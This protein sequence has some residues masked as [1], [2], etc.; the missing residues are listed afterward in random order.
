M[1]M[2]TPPFTAQL[3]ADGYGNLITISGE[4]VCGISEFLTTWGLVVGLTPHGYKRRYCFECRLDAT[5]ALESWR[6]LCGEH[7]P[8]PWIK[9]KGVGIDLLNPEL[10]S[11]Q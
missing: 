11:C 10:T 3:E 8:G 6:L 7:P 2:L 1:S 4:G 9:C 5:L